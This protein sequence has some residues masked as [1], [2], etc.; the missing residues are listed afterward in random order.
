MIS[1]ETHLSPTSREAIQE[2]TRIG[3]PK[4]KWTMKEDVDAVLVAG[5]PSEVTSLGSNELYMPLI[6][7]I[8]PTAIAVDSQVIDDLFNVDL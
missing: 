3:P 4:G 2:V 8:I 7:Q 6:M 5:L 1:S